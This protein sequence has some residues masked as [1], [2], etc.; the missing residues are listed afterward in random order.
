MKSR[1]ACKGQY[2]KPWYKNLGVPFYLIGS[3]LGLVGLI[4]VFFGAKLFRITSFLI[5]SIAFTL[6]FQSLLS[7]IYNFDYKSN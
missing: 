1:Y 7:T 2:F 3:I 6:L 5:V 4:Y